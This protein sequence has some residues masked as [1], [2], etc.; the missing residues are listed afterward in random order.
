MILLFL[1]DRKKLQNIKRIKDH[2]RGIKSIS[3]GEMALFFI[4]DI[5]LDESLQHKINKQYKRAHPWI[6][7]TWKRKIRCNILNYWGDLQ[8]HKSQAAFPFSRRN[9]LFSSLSTQTFS[10]P[11]D[12]R[13]V[14]HDSLICFLF[15]RSWQWMGCL[16]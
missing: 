12:P 1:F 8:L 15:G 14:S 4:Q 11:K 5:M 10:S 16:S 9:K 6:H 13:S 3:L 2:E 7:I